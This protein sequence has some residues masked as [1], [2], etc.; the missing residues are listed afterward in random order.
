MVVRHATSTLFPYAT[1]FRSQLTLLRGERGTPAHH[2]NARAFRGRDGRAGIRRQ[3]RP[4]TRVFSASRD[5]LRQGI[6]G[7]SEEHTSELQSLAYL[8]CRLL[9]EKK[10]NVI[11]ERRIRIMM[12]GLPRTRFLRHYFIA[13]I[14]HYQRFD[15]KLYYFIIHPVGSFYILLI[16]TLF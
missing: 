5:A 9:L 4:E 12:S 8:V 3:C 6:H 11:M 7:R 10:K 16:L 15:A 14:I 13:E 2:C 1:L